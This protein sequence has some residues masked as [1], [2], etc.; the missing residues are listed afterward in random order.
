MATASS[1][2]P[3]SSPTKQHLSAGLLSLYCQ[4]ELRSKNTG[5]HTGPT[6]PGASFATEDAVSVNSVVDWANL[7]LYP[8]SGWITSS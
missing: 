6:G 1:G 7:T 8:L 3:S 2:R 4:A 5:A